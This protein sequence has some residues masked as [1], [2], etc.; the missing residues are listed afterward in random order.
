MNTQTFDELAGKEMVEKTEK[1]LTEHGFLPET[2]ETGAEAFARIKELIPAGVTVMNGSSKT[3]E[4]IGYIDYLA[5]GKHPWINPKDAILAEKDPEK[6]KMLRKKAV[7]SDWYLGSAHAI[8][9]DGQ[10]VVASNT[11]SQ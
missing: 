10:I 2:V 7:V 9:E 4:E 3:L 11:G 6:Q 8:T 1:T 5:S